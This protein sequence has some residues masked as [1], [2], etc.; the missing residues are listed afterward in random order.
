MVIYISGNSRVKLIMKNL[1]EL[2]LDLW[3]LLNNLSW[4]LRCARFGANSFPIINSFN[5]DLSITIRVTLPE[6]FQPI[7][8]ERYVK[9]VVFGGHKG[10]FRADN[11]DHLRRELSIHPSSSTCSRNSSTNYSRITYSSFYDISCS[12]H[13]A[14]LLRSRRHSKQKN[15]PRQVDELRSNV[16][17]RRRARSKGAASN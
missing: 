17:I 15:P 4:N 12:A 13:L 2:Y 11:A 3:Y 14:P 6:T 8:G 7:I 10:R 5:K 1:I 9:I 16:V